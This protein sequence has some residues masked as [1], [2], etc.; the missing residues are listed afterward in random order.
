[1]RV[2][3]LLALAGVLYADD[4]FDAA[5]AAL[6]KVQGRT[7]EP[8]ARSILNPVIEKLAECDD[9]RVA[10]ALAGYM[11]Y[12][13]AGERK[14]DEELKV[15]Q[16]AGAAA[17]ELIQAIDKELRHLVLRLKAGAH[18]VGPRIEELKLNRVRQERIFSNA[19]AETSRLHRAVSFARELRDKVLV[20]GAGSLARQPKDRIEV[21]LRGVRR[22][23]DVK[24]EAQAL[25]TVRILR[26]SRRVEAVPHLVDVLNHPGVAAGA[27]RQAILALATHDDPRGIDAL[28]KAWQRDPDG[29]GQHARYAL[30]LVARRPLKDLD[31]AR[32]WARKHRG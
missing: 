16:A 17:N 27:R 32:A 11:A 25:L 20:L 2:L 24:R 7:F 10:G 31:D 13:L 23:L 1:M 18:E 26:E 8:G 21:G 15:I 12:T 3:V 6:G 30:S 9:P 19:R 29:T 4:S 14:V 28:L 5:V 22:A